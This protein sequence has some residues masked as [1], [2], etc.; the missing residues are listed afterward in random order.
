MRKIPKI[1]CLATVIAPSLAICKDNK[2]LNVV[3]I[4]ADDFGYECVTAN[5]GESYNTPNI[6]RLA[7]RGIRFSRCYS[8]P[9]STPSRVQLMTGRYNI[10][11]Y[12]SFGELDRSETTFGNLLKSNGYNT[13]I[14]GKWQLGKEID[15]P[16][17]FGFDEACL[18]QHTA[19]AYAPDR[20]DSRFANPVMEHNGEPI[21]YTNGEFGPDVAADF[22]IDFINKNQQEPF[23]VYYPMILTHCPFVATPDSK[24]WKAE[25]SA[26][27]KGNAKYFKD[28]VEYGDKLVGKIVDELDRLNLTDN[29]LIIF[30]GDNGTDQPVVT[31]FKGEPY[32]GGKS[33]TMDSG[34]HV[35]LVVLSPNGA[36]GTVN[37]N[38]IDF[39][40]FL[41]TICD[42]TDI[43]IPK[44]IDIDGSSFYPQV[45]GKMKNVRDWTYCWY[46]PRDVRDEIAKVFARDKE[47]KLYRDGRLFNTQNDIYEKDA[48]DIDN[49]TKEQS[50][51]YQKLKDVIANYDNYLLKQ[52]R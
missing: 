24:D 52:I 23:F 47:Y 2:P 12:I 16:Q 6:D 27:Y 4:M 34:I 15:S 5:G 26:T 37:D 51:I 45:K 25:R 17:H 20:K 36:N 10:K 18:W 50:K 35:P 30:T 44:N 41:P 38:L 31:T 33:F 3:L 43:K 29:T 22:I 49:L 1:A 19:G 46:A 9:L 14:A 7:E 8:N 32:P 13:C 48:L 21:E 40:D 28:M 11:N 42:A 39:T